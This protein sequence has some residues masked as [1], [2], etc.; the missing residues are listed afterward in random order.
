MAAPY[1]EVLNELYLRYLGRAIDPAGYI[2]YSSQ[3]RRGRMTPADIA[4]DLQE[5]REYRARL[6]AGLQPIF[7]SVVDSGFGDSADG[8]LR[9]PEYFR[10]AEHRSGWAYAMGGLGRL[11]HS[12]G[13]LLDDFVE[14]RFA[15]S[16][17]SS[18]NSGVIPYRQ[19]WVGI[20]HNP[21]DMPAWFDYDTSPQVV[22]SRTCMQ[23]SIPHCR[24]LFALSNHLAKWLQAHVDVPVEVLTH[25]AEPATVRFNFEAFCRSRERKLMQIGVWLR[26]FH[27]IR[28]LDAPGYLKMWVLTHDH[29]RNLAAREAATM[30]IYGSDGSLY[31]GNYMECQW[32]RHQAYDFLLSR[33]IVFLDA[34][35][36]SAS[37]TVVECIERNTPILIRNLPAAREY[38][39]EDYPFYF[40]NLDEA[41]AKLR[42]IDLVHDTHLYLRA[43]D[44][45]RFTR[46]NLCREI[47]HSRIWSAL[48][49]VAQG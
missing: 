25:P 11:H 39:G 16:V 44:K 47:E 7:S 41:S 43:L 38:L 18:V 21:P 35:D 28:F 24:G 31:T 6:E 5:S 48:P 4:T 46:E 49:R 32:L 2:S 27:S 8:R 19:P 20:V 13:V 10:I 12:D 23:E 1:F 30:D 40:D 42:E 14:N 29:A 45:S 3:L 22:F 34:Y 26:R 9:L 37:N 15:M 17:F 33:N 36:M